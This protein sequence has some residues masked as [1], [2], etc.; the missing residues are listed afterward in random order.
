[1]KLKFYPRPAAYGNG[2]IILH[3]LGKW[4][5]RTDRWHEGP[6]HAVL[7]MRH[8]ANGGYTIE[9]PSDGDGDDD[10]RGAGGGGYGGYGS[11]GKYI[12]EPISGGGY[13]V[14][15]SATYEG[16]DRSEDDIGGYIV[17]SLSNGGYIVQN[18]SRIGGYIILRRAQGGAM[19]TRR[20]GGYIVQPL[21]EVAKVFQELPPSNL[22]P[23][24]VWQCA[25]LAVG[26]S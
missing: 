11:G 21:S 8:S 12:V 17:Q 10:G 23:G 15:L 20:G 3:Y 14:K 16:H 24:G 18:R 6:P 25:A 2:Y 19:G 1:M 5:G 22:L 4:E 26:E 7:V 13:E 9:P